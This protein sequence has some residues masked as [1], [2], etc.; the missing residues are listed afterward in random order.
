MFMLRICLSNLYDRSY[1]YRNTEL[2][3][4]TIESWLLSRTRLYKP[5]SGFRQALAA[6]FLTG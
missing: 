2:T 4:S 6:G 1:I 3:S 5:G